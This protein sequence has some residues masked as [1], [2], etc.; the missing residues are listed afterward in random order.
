MPELAYYSFGHAAQVFAN[1]DAYAGKEYG[2][3]FMIASERQ[4]MDANSI[5]Y[6]QGHNGGGAA[7]TYTVLD[8]GTGDVPELVPG[9][10][11]YVRGVIEGAGTMVGDT[12]DSVD[13]LWITV[14]EVEKDVTGAD[15]S[16]QVRKI[17]LAEGACSA[18][19]GTLTIDVLSLDFTED[20][21]M[22]STKTLDTGVKQFET[23]YIDII[24]HQEGCFAWYAGCNF[25][26]HPD[27]A[28]YD[29][30]PLPP[31]DSA[32]DMT[33]EFVPFDESGALLYEPLVIDI[34]AAGDV[35]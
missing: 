35:S 3:P 25:W 17:S 24:V 9:E 33:I 21:L 26:I 11:V 30:I 5:Y 7:Q 18:T 4:Q 2:S 29:N 28:G 23:Y 31:M 12:G 13:V 34:P 14:S 19:S 20:A 1:P 16:A 32:K 6:A 15:I 8:F 22:L 27:A 10:V